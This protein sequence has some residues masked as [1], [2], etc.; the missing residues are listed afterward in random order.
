[1]SYG[2]EGLRACPPPAP[3]GV[4]AWRFQASKASGLQAFRPSGLVAYL[5]AG[6]GL[7]AVVLLGPTV[8]ATAQNGAWSL[9]ERLAAVGP[10]IPGTVES[11]TAR[12][13]LLDAM[14][15]AGLTDLRAEQIAGDP[16]VINLSGRVRGGSGPEVLLT[17]H[18]D[19]V[20][21]SPGA[22]DDASGCAVAIRAAEHLVG[23]ELGVSVR[24][25]LFDGEEGGL[26]GSRGYVAS[27]AYPGTV[28]AVVNLDSLG[29]RDARR[30][31]AHVAPPAGDAT[32][33]PPAWLLDAALAAARRTR[34]ALEPGEARLPVPGQL[35]ERYGRLAYTSDAAPFLAAGWPA[36]LLSDATLTD[37]GT[38]V[39]TPAD[40]VRHLDAERLE[41]WRRFVVALVEELDIRVPRAADAGSTGDYLV[42]AG[43][44]WTRPALW[45]TGGLLWVLL[46]WRL[47]RGAP[48]SA[49]AMPL[50]LALAAL[51][52][53]L[54]PLGSAL[55]LAP[56]M[57][58]GIVAPRPL[59]R[60]VPSA[61]GGLLPAAVLLGFAGWALAVGHLLGVRAEAWRL[62]LPLAAVAAYGVWR[63][64]RG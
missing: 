27:L 8:P 31:V 49:P 30:A 37:L 14:A 16:P 47:L 11:R 18:Y 62:L 10:R 15:A 58:I 63:L 26:H 57:L 52:W 64:R 59:G 6:A 34:F 20:A 50:F 56:A 43:A 55:L 4:K 12:R 36:L 46:A 13:L 17:A 9:A 1:M 29:S 3:P 33:A 44:L 38:D 21:G 5:R 35:L 28:A 51:G 23:A 22:L 32:R 19:T 60:A 48:R 54:A 2:E 42:V 41:A 53:A 40:T 25:V 61:V 24:V 39:H 45:I 7:L